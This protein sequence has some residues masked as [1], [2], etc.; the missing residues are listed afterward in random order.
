MTEYI[1]Y[2]NSSLVWERQRIISLNFHLIH[3]ILNLNMRKC[4]K[5]YTSKY[6]DHYALQV[7]NMLLD[8]CDADCKEWGLKEVGEIMLKELLV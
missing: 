4:I 8:F 5:P 1:T 2:L 3:P 6:S 7:C